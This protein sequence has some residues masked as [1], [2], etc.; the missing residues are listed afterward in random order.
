MWHTSQ[1]NAF[2]CMMICL[3]NLAG[4]DSS[5][6]T[7]PQS[8][9]CAQS[10]RYQYTKTTDMSLSTDSSCVFADGTQTREESGYTQLIASSGGFSF[11]GGSDGRWQ[12]DATCAGD[13]QAR[14]EITLSNDC[15]IDYMTQAVSTADT[16]WCSSAT[17]LYIAPYSIVWSCGE[18]EPA[19]LARESW[20]L[21]QEE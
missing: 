10:G 1:W 9:P 20:V 13:E 14:I 21:K 15:V 12:I 16:N 7:T 4:C 17:C 5:D 18:E 2:T 11:L 3:F 8:T 6:T 19:C